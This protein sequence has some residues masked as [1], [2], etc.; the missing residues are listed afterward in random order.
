LQNNILEIGT[1]SGYQSA[2]LSRLWEQ[3]YTMERIK[4]LQ[5]RAQQVLTDLGLLNIEFK[6]ADGYMGWP[7]KSPF[8]AIILTA[9]SPVV[10]LK[11]VNQL[12]DGGSMILPIGA[13]EQVQMLTLIT[14]KGTE[15]EQKEIEP[16]R[17]VPMLP[18]LSQ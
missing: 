9:A 18:G 11:L 4:V 12:A 10:P 2:I 15:I 14:K 8:E 13:A 7:E 17:F 6:L 1:G 3:V 5:T 16:V